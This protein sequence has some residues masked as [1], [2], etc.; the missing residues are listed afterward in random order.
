MDTLE[1]IRQRI[2]TAE[3]LHSLVRTMKALAAVN[4]RQFEQAVEALREYRETL[5]LSL[6]AALRGSSGGLPWAREAAP[7]RLG[8]I[9]CGSD[10]GMCGP[11]NERVVRFTCDDFERL[12]FARE[13]RHVVVV[14]QRAASRMAERGERIDLVLPVAN[15]VAGLTSLAERLLVEID[16][17]R[18]SRGIDRVVVYYTEHRS[19]V[20]YE[21]K[22]VDLLPIDR[23]WLEAQGEQPWPTRMIPQVTGSTETMFLDLI[24]QAIF[25]SL[26]RALAESQASEN[27]SRLLTMRGAEQ[28]IGEQLEDLTR[29]YH[30]QRQMAITEELLDIAS[31]AESLGK[32]S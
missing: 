28:S 15:T 32:D 24:R 30:R 3:Q 6:R 16:Q 19:R 25:V 12:E 26:Y 2:Q 7:T 29:V 9:V 20:A 14:G 18:E 4:I 27:A 21:P 31:G 1:S 8:A 10:Q 23:R 22:R 13:Q 11:I 5:E 17:W